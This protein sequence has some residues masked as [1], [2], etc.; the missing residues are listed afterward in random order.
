MGHTEHDESSN[1]STVVGV[2]AASGMCLAN[3]CLATGPKTK[4]DWAGEDQ[5]QFAMLWNRWVY[6]HR[7]SKGIS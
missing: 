4:N 1:S 5:Q 2:I 7:D 6:K 3:R